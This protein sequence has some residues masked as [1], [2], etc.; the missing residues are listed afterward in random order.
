MKINFALLKRFATLAVLVLTSVFII[1][2]VFS[3]LTQIGDIWKNVSL[4]AILL[5]GVLFL[6]YLYFR[7]VSWFFILKSLGKY[8]ALPD[9]FSTWF[10]GESARYIPG[11]VWS[12][13]GRVYLAKQ[14]N[15]PRRVTSL[16]LAIEISLLLMTTAILS[17]PAIIETNFLV[18]N[19]KLIW[20]EI[21]L[22]LI[23]L[24]VVGLLIFAPLSRY[25]LKLKNFW[26]QVGKVNFHLILLAS[27]L[28]ILAWSCYGLAGWYFI[29]QLAPQINLVLV[30][31][32]MIF[33]W[34]I[35][36]LS[37]VTPMGLG[38]REGLLVLI[39][40][41]LI[42]VV[43]ATVAALFL[44]GIL[45]IS[46]VI[47]LILWS[48][49]QQ[50]EL[51]SKLW[52]RIM[53]RLDLITLSALMIIY[54]VVMSV[55]AILRH[56][57]FASNYDLANMDQTIWNTMHGNVFMMTQGTDLI[58][59]LSTH[60]DL[61]LILLSPL[62][63]LWNDVRFLLVAQ[64]VLLSLGAI[65]V[66]LLAKKLLKNS[67]LGLVIVCLYLLNPGMQWTNLYDFHAVALA[68]PLL[69][70][71]FYF[72]YQASHDQTNWR[73]YWLFFILALLT[74]EE[75]SLFLAMMGLAIA[76]F[77][78]AWKQGLLSLLIGLVWFPM[79]IFLVI[80]HFNPAG[81]HWAFNQ[82]FLPTK[83]DLIQKNYLGLLDLIKGDAVNSNAAA[84]YLALLKPFSFLP[85]LGLPWVLLGLPEVLINITSG[86]A[87]MQSITLHYDSGVTPALVIGV[88]FALSYLVWILKK[89]PLS[90]H[91]DY[92]S[93]VLGV[94][95]IFIAA[96][97][98]YHFGPL[99][100]SPSCWCY[101]YRTDQDD[102]QFENVL[103]K[104]PKEASVAASGEVRPHVSHRINSYSLPTYTNQTDYIA[105]IDQ[106]RLIG[107]SSPHSFE[108][109]LIKQF[110]QPDSQFMLVT[111]LGHF[112]LYKNVNSQY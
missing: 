37:L 1:Q 42:G 108:V 72:A 86:Y 18:E 53:A 80:P 9:N 29:N 103:Q 19:F 58:S 87:G 83:E 61:I 73:W 70:T 15:I 10:L 12:F 43:P 55:L 39:I 46:E 105:L 50:K 21:T 107:D 85:L 64:S 84:Y 104:I 91:S 88:T 23:L 90:R 28:Q 44:R 4:D 63:L 65:P 112:Y 48:Y 20:L 45:V 56:N 49:L 5:S 99:P 34:L 71:T 51:L 14:K 6:L 31:S 82:W 16:S 62:Y 76:I 26:Q 100:I 77:Y 52:H 27:V 95:L 41:P 78:K 102:Y 36:Y 69:L 30:F 35:G 3:N 68:I 93:V 67:F 98:D 60:V 33:V 109:G 8:L 24:L 75:I 81:Q 54:A 101:V 66:F 111:H 38:V 89:S 11:N 17:I 32:S 13:L 25:F 96:R 94:S 92:L 97:V 79:M 7:A 106:N 47:N 22:L 40:G 110:S 57:S 2:V 74:K 59:R